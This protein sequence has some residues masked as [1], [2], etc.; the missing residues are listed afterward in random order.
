MAHMNVMGKTA[1]VTGATGF[2]GGALAHRLAA[3]GAQVRALARS[4]QKAGL[5]QHVPGIEIV[6]GDVT[7]AARMGELVQGC[8]LVFQVAAA[9][10][11]WDEQRAVN[12]EG[13]RHVAQAAAKAKAERMV[14][15]SSIAVYGYARKGHI[16]EDEPFASV[17]YEPYSATKFQG[18]KIVQEFSES[19]GLSYAIIRPGMIYG[20]RAEQWT[21]KPFRLA[22]RRPLIWI[23]DGRG[24]T[25]PI[26]VDDV[27]DLLLLVATHPA[28]HNQ[29][30]NAVHPVPVTWREFLLAYANLA[31]HQSWLGI[32]PV[33]ANMGSQLIGALSPTGSRLKA[34]PD[35]VRGLQ[36]Q[37][38]IDMTKAR[39]LLGWE[40]QMDL[41]TGIQS[42]VPYLREKRLI[43]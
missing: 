26:H 7:D 24:S 1:L 35:A 36:A 33:F 18:E 25:F 15:V 39:T 37:G 27:V 34:A 29:I 21:L 20:P 38:V 28:A 3:E 17:E 13:T 4:P 16:T 5:L 14:Y 2:L 11:D 32:P 41:Q 22:R 31:G 9:F 43:R 30:F 19:A 40:P 6:P 10:G 42:C 12:V 23:G 8:H